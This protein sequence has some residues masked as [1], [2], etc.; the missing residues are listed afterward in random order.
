MSSHNS[1]DDMNNH[2]R[3]IAASQVPFQVPLEV[4]IILIGFSGDGGY[5][6]TLNSQKLQEFLQVGFPTHRPS[7]LETGEPLYIEHHMVFNAIP[8]GQPEV[9]AL[10]KALKA[11]MVPAGISRE[12]DFGR[13]VPVFEINA[14][15]VE[16]EFQK[17]YSYMFYFE[18]IGYSIEEIDR[19]MPT[20]IFIVN[21][22]K[23]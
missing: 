12:T 20:A 9:I 17:L 10:E 1:P 14:T 21:F 7:C 15:A 6:Y 8:V 5:R 2:S 16:P 23:V 19:P 13:E 11:A 18:N 3:N 22:D 4:N